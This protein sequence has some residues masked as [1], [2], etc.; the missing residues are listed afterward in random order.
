[1]LFLFFDQKY[2]FFFKINYKIWKKKHSDAFYLLIYF[3]KWINLL[4]C[5]SIYKFLLVTLYNKVSFVN[6]S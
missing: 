2:N 3:K 4:L 6:I 1:M 5:L